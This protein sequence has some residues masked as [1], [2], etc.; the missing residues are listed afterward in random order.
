MWWFHLPSTSS[1]SASIAASFITCVSRVNFSMALYIATSHVLAIFALQVLPSCRWQTL[2]FTGMLFYTGVLGVTAGAHR[3][4]AHKSY[5]AHGLVR[6]VLMLWQSTSLQGSIFDW[7]RWHR[8][9]HKFAETDLDPHNIHRG[10]FYAHMG[11]LVTRP[12]SRMLAAVAAVPCDDLLQDWVVAM[13]HRFHWVLNP[14]MCFAMPVAVSSFLWREDWTTALLVAGFLR[15]VLVMHATCVPNSVTHIVG[16]KP[17][18]AVLSAHDSLW[19]ALVSL[20]E[21]YQ[22]WHHQFPQDYAA[23]EDECPWQF[24]ATK[25]FIDGCA[26]AGLAGHRQRALHL[27]GQKKYV[28][29]SRLLDELRPFRTCNPSST[30]STSSHVGT[31]LSSET[32]K[33]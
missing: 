5:K 20:G 26:M 25:A 18:N 32:M 10:L 13:Q 3:L 11:W 16:S 28:L 31:R 27:W 22:N 2:V 21:G 17:Y 4:W 8:L 12:T 6:V 9:H 14:I 1:S 24:N 19:V 33:N 15:Q 29:R 30:S 7:S 23:A